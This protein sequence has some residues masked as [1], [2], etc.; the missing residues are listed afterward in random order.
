MTTNFDS[1]D[2]R[3]HLLRLLAQHEIRV[4]VLHCHFSTHEEDL[5]NSEGVVIAGA[6]HSGDW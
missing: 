5:D 4:M 3:A 2:L 6:L 1:Y